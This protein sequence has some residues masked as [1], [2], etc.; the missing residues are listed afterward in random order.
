M[1][2]TA[3]LYRYH[4][5]ISTGKVLRT[6]KQDFRN[7][8]IVELQENSSVGLG[9]IA[10]LPNFSQENLQQATQQVQTWL[11]AWLAG[12]MP[13]VETL[14]PSVAFGLS[15]ALAE[16]NGELGEAMNTQSAVLC[17]METVDLEKKLQGKTLAKIKVG[18]NPARDEGIWI[19]HLLTHF[20]DLQ[21][22]LDANRAWNLDEACQFAEQ[23]APN[24]RSRLQFIE[25]PCQNIALSRQFAAQ[26]QLPL[27]WDESSRQAD[28]TLQ[29]EPYLKALIIKPTLT[30]SLQKC[31][32]Q[33]WQ[34]QQLGITAVI[35]SSLES[36]LALTQLARI[37]AQYT[38]DTAVGLDTLQLMPAQLVR[39]Y[40]DATLPLITLQQP[41]HFLQKIPLK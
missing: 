11:N 38:P 1:A 23:L 24:H 13:C 26:H 37:A 18:R 15:C 7:G 29:N 36:S 22:R 34:A 31:I 27:A 6:G 20:P 19:N 33:I 21:L 40:P 41:Y 8:L 39:S 9:E 28:F 2:R 17:E 16:L 12:D 14:F 32:A 3:Q 25:E 10:P 35:S 30:G 5:P 4:L